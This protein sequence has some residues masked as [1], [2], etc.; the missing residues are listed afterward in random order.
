M[1]EPREPRPNLTFTHLALV[2]PQ[3]PGSF[4]WLQDADQSKARGLL[5]AKSPASTECEFQE[6]HYLIQ[7]E[8]ARMDGEDS[9]GGER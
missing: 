8:H 4:C 3:P 1:A 6:T 5:K 9:D 2:L 7:G